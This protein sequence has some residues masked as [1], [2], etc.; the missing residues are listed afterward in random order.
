M[1]DINTSLLDEIA[2][3][4]KD[5]CSEEEY[6]KYGSNIVR[7]KFLELFINKDSVDFRRSV[8]KQ[9]T[10]LQREILNSKGF[11]VLLVSHTF[12]IKVFLICRKELNLFNTPIIIKE[13]INPSKR[14]MEHCQLSCI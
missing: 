12:F 10:S 1:I 4:L 9:C 13:Y 11:N 7:L 6:N 8:E 2:F 5:V 14:I 3:H